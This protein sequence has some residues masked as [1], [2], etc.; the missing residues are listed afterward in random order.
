MGTFFIPCAG[1]NPVAVDVKGHRLLILS[2]LPEDVIGE[3][4]TLGANVVQE[5]TLGENDTRALARLAESVKGGVVL[6]PPGVSVSAMIRNLE[7]ELP[8]LH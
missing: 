3:L 6:S 7:A 4:E 8:W 1:K 2:S 5:V